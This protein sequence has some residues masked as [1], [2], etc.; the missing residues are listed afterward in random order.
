M[1][2]RCASARRMLSR[3]RR[4]GAWACSSESCST[5]QRPRPRALP[6]AAS[7]SEST[8]GYDQRHTGTM[9]QL[10]G[11]RPGAGV[12]SGADGACGPL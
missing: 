11:R 12:D 8:R 3:R 5:Q 7:N 1:C 10:G 9:R 2:V 6:A 4:A